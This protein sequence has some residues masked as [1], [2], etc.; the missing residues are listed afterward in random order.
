V[1]AISNKGIIDSVNAAFT[2]QTGIPVADAVGK[3]LD[4]IL[5]AEAAIVGGAAR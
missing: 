2:R 4:A 5:M 1:L 3:S